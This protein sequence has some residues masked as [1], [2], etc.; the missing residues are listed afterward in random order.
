M[1]LLVGDIG[2]THVRL[3]LI[4]EGG[5]DS[6]ILGEVHGSS[7]DYDS[8]ERALEHGLQQLRSKQHGN[9][10][11]ACLAVAG[12]VR[13]DRVRFTNRDWTVDVGQLAH[14]LRLPRLRI[15][16][17]LEA[18]AR[19]LDFLSSADL[20]TLKSGR[21]RDERRLVVGIGT[22]LGLAVRHDREGVLDSEGGHA[23]FA[24]MDEDQLGLW[25]MLRG[26]YG[27]VSYERV[28][29]G[30]GLACVYEYVCAR[31][32]MPPVPG[33]REGGASP[34]RVTELADR[35]DANALRAME[36]FNRVLGG[37]LGNAA[38]YGLTGGGV[39]LHGGVPLNIRPHLDFDVVE[40]AFLDKGRMEDRLAEIP[41][42]LINRTDAPLLGARWVA[43]SLL[44]QSD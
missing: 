12:T 27:H 6:A 41:I 33:Y 14:R 32:R 19:G 5:A 38:L 23:D 2:G 9:I 15:I 13:G 11:G 40:R 34:A 1:T 3:R 20:L 10:R 39:Y 36:L 37:F 17:D 25:C 29:S 35:N 26:R 28:L 8:L 24:P 42:H 21:V 16:N 18:L 7:D 30:A 43:Q 4:G 44:A 22:G 31:R